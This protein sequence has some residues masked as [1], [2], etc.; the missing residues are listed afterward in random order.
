MAYSGICVAVCVVIMFLGSVLELGMYASPLIVGMILMFMGQMFGSAWHRNLFVATSALCLILVPHIEANLMLV[1]FF[2]WYPL[3]RP[4]LQ[5]LP[6]FFSWIAK[7]LI[8]NLTVISIEYIVVTFLVPE[9]LTSWMIIT[10]LIL[11]NITFIMYDILIPR[12][13][14]VMAHYAKKL[15]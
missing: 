15:K 2:G 7:I 3:V 13:Q 8:F 6:K 12:L 1:G 4:S 10:L 9:F 5:K 14:R 11:A